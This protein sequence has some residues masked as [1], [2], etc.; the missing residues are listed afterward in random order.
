MQAKFEF[1]QTHGVEEYYIY[2]PEIY[3]LQGWLRQGQQ[4]LPITDVS[5]WVS[6]RLG[7]RFVGQFNQDLEIYYPDG[8]KF[9]STLELAAQA[10]QQNT[11]LQ[12]TAMRLLAGGMPREQVAQLMDL[13][14]EQLRL[15]L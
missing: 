8:R 12:Q 11:Q 15:W 9:T 6:P 7:I 10:E 1:Y 3:E 14:P 2:D 13:S 4:L 5:N